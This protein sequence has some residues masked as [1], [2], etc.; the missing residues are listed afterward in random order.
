M[1]GESK[2][3]PSTEIPSIGLL[4]LGTFLVGHSDSMCLGGGGA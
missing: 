1:H 3:G 2:E 4:E